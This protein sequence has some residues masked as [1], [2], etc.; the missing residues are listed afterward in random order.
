MG[1]GTSRTARQASL[2][3]GVFGEKIKMKNEEMLWDIN[4]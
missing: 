2:T 3:P 4:N 1:A